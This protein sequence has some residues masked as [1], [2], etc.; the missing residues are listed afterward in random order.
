M[1]KLCFLYGQ[2]FEEIHIERILMTR[3]YHSGN[4]SCRFSSSMISYNSDDV[5]S[6]TSPISH[7]WIAT[8]VFFK[9]PLLLDPNF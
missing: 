5:L 1:V 7:R 8:A 2:G 6:L 3:K 9:I 4:N